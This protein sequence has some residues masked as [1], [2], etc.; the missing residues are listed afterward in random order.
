MHA[1]SSN[2]PTRPPTRVTLL[3]L[4]ALLAST[5]ALEVPPALAAAAHATS[6]AALVPLVAAPRLGA[7]PAHAASC[8][9][10][11]PTDCVCS[12]AVTATGESTKNMNKRADAAGRDA[13]QS[14]REV[15][16]MR[17]AEEGAAVGRPKGGGKQK[18]GA[19]GG[20]GS[21]DVNALPAQ[22]ASTSEA[23]QNFN[24]RSVSDAKAR[25]ADVL[26]QTVAKKEATLGRARARHG[27]GSR[28]DPARALLRTRRADR[29]VLSRLD[30]PLH[31]NVPCRCAES[32]EYV[33]Q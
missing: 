19:G 13:N 29:P 22:L 26:A 15:E 18:G 27:Q 21:L 5:T 16:Q 24:E 17:A 9:C 32:E 8:V 20:P 7:A 30:D 10:T 28:E 4:F 12:D 1:A 31:M 25:F 6:R 33:P 23:T 14:R 3:A 2:L 11:T